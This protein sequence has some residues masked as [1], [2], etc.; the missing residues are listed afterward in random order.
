MDMAGTGAL[1]VTLTRTNEL[2]AEVLDQLKETN[3][4]RL[5]AVVAEL[6]EQSSA[7]NGSSATN[8]PGV[9]R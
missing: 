7:S 2:L 4:V 3:S 9:Q 8:D 1:Q 5:E 6:R